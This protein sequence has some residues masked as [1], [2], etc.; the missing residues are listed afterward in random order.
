MLISLFY[1][2]KMENSITLQN[3]THNLKCTHFKKKR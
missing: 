1:R 2:K 3:L